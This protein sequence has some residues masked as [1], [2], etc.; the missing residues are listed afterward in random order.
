MKNFNIYILISAVALSVLLWPAQT[1]A[2]LVTSDR[3]RAVAE[4]Y[5]TLIIES[6]GSWGG[7]PT[8]SVGS[9][10]E[11]RREGRLLGYWC[12]VEPAGHIVVSLHKALAPVKASSETWDSDPGC[13]ADIIDVIKYKIEQEHDFIEENIGPVATAPVDEVA[14][15]CEISYRDVWTLLDRDAG[16]FEQSQV[17]AGAA[18][19]YQEGGVMLS[20]SWN[21]T[22]PY[23]L[24]MPATSACGPGYDDRC[25]AGCVAIAAGQIM[26]YWDWPPYGVGIPYNDYYDWTLMPDQLTTGSPYQQID[27]TALFIVEVGQACGMDWCKDGGCASSAHHTD[28]RSAFMYI[29]RFSPTA[30]IVERPSYSSEAW[31]NVIRDNINGNMPLQY[32]V[33]DH[34]IVCDGWRIVSDV[35]QYHMNY[36]WGD[37]L[38]SDSCWDPYAGSGSNTWFTL[39]ALPCSE[40]AVEEAIVLLKPIVSLGPTL[41][42]TYSRDSSFPY[43]YVNVDAGGANTVFQAGQLIQSLPGL[44][45]R[46]TSTGSGAVRFY[47]SPTLHTRIF[48]RGDTSK[49]VK[50]TDGCVALYGGGAVLIH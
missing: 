35:K 2:Q 40:L 36:G 28:M 48:T 37:W 14:R 25:A 50:I 4:N 30:W 1:S 21:Q 49:G 17:L 9:I 43:R 6:N 41:S 42:S 33:P 46:C 8:A 18:T 16:G 12:H 26:K 5:I 27:E 47:G 44:T 32:G 7:S 23:N 11:L 22:D 38:G 29:F 13:N 20:T 3:A 19:N 39:D 24:F 31:F 15:F 45:V 34:S 10:D